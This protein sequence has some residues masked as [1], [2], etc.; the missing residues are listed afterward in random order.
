MS[1]EH[2]LLSWYTSQ[3][4]YHAQDRLGWPRRA[5]A[6][7]LRPL[8]PTLGALSPRGGPVQDPVRTE[9][10]NRRLKN[11]ELRSSDVSCSFMWLCEPTGS[12][13]YAPVEESRAE[14]EHGPTQGHK[15]EF[16]TQRFVLQGYL[17]HK[18]PPPPP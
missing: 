8:I 5:P 10:A 9:A 13:Y 12:V 17:A 6:E 14:N 7:A 15:S 3:R 18:N 16:Q 2:L 11:R 4:V 1:L